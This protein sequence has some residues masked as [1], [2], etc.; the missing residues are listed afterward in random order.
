MAFPNDEDRLDEGTEDLDQAERSGDNARDVDVSERDGKTEVEVHRESRRERKEREFADRRQK[1]IDSALTPIRHQNE[2]L[3]RQLSE[4]SSLLQRQ[5]VQQQARQQHEDDGID[6]D[7]EIIKEKQAELIRKARTAKSDEDAD[8][9][10]R[11]Y[12]KLD[13]KA[14]DLRAGKLVDERLKQYRPPQQM[15]YQEQ[16]LRSDF[17]DVFRNPQAERYAS[18]L[19][20][21][22]E[23]LALARGEQVNPLKVRQDALLKAAHD[24]GIRKAETPAPK[25]SQAARMSNRGD[26]AIPVRSNDRTTK[27]TLTSDER[28]AAIASGD[29]DKTPEQNISRWTQRMEK[30]GYWDAD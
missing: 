10:S 9:L 26:R 17:Q 19:V 7:L 18:S 14:I 23:T 29:P 3:T 12:R 27:R 5:P 22:A 8:R 4:L 1:E 2:A 6:P 11:E 15:N 16:Q 30:A 25:P 24:F 21:Q 13:Q 20:T 28:K